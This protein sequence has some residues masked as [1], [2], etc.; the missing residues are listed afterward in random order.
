MK[1]TEP[2]GLWGQPHLD[3]IPA[4]LLADLENHGASVPAHKM[5]QKEDLPH[6]VFVGINTPISASATPGAHCQWKREFHC[7][8]ESRQKEPWGREA[9]RVREGR[10]MCPECWACGCG[11]GLK[12]SLECHP[13][14]M[15][16]SRELACKQKVTCKPA[17][18][19]KG[20]LEESGL[21]WGVLG[22]GAQDGEHSHC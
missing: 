12:G 2:H 15:P 20:P 5:R 16:S 10:G 13:E 19:S 11:G 6:R 14:L 4:P 7:D 21:E 18:R 9:W 8:V 17:S 3:L 22:E 1:S